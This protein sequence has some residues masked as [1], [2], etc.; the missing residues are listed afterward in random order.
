M[1]PSFAVKSPLKLPN[2][3]GPTLV[4][5]FWGFFTAYRAIFIVLLMYTSADK[6]KIINVL[7]LLVS[8]VVLVPHANTDKSSLYAGIILLGLGMCPIFAATYGSLTRYFS[9]TSRMTAAFFISTCV[10]HLIYPWVVSKYISTYPIIF[11]YCIAGLV[12]STSILTT[13][14]PFIGQKYLQ[15]ATEQRENEEAKAQQ[16]MATIET[17]RVK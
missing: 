7:L 10:G 5:I 11:L 6:A 16:T 14:I 3:S 2:E 8:I 9:V 17:I 4:S 12:V 1:G 13:I 15:Y